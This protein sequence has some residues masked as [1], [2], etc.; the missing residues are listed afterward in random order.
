MIRPSA[1]GDVCRTVP[2]LVS[3]R[4]RWPDA[5]IDWLVQAEFAPAIMHHPDL[6]RVIP[7]Q[8]K[9]MG[10]A[11]SRGRFSILGAFV[12]QLKRAQ[13][14]IVF[15]LQGLA[16]SGF[17]ARATGAPRRIGFANA[18]ELGWIGLTDRVP[19][20]AEMH[21]VER[22]LALLPAAGVAPIR[23][24]RLYTGEEERLQ[25]LAD[26]D[27]PSGGYVML[28][29]GSR[30]PGKCW[31]DDRFA[32]VAL[33]VLDHG[34]KVLL[35]GSRSEREQASKLLDL[36]DRDKRV[37]DRMGATSIGQLMAMIH[38]SRAVIA[39]DSAALHMAVGFDKPLIALYGP[40]RV[41]L[42]GPYKRDSDVLQHAEPG[43]TFDHK[44]AVTGRRMMERIHADEVITRLDAMML[45][46]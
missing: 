22:M 32:K 14:D 2:V 13:Y 42:V 41:D 39:N 9:E 38:F 8:R 36:A 28:A 21:T 33:R 30:W 5:E 43:D 20:S 19:V 31:P 44:Q 18:R 12:A 34:Y 26:P 1:L 27:L 23:N 11:L 15:D 10:S 35:V 4:S 7:F 40:T 3:L 6:T 16:R 17:F 29:P 45:E 37:V 25:V 46:S 24:M